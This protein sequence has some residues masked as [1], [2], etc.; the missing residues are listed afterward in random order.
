M[1]GVLTHL[2]NKRHG[3]QTLEQTIWRLIQAKHIIYRRT[4]WHFNSTFDSSV[5]PSTAYQIFTYQEIRSVITFSL[6]IS[7]S[8]TKPTGLDF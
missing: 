8:I 7:N 2:I 3:S 5:S 1:V 6:D 4:L